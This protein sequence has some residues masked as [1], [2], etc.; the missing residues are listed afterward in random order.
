MSSSDGVGSGVG[1]GNCISMPA[2][3]G[4]LCGRGDI[5]IESLVG[6]GDEDGGGGVDRTS[7]ISFSAHLRSISVVLNLPLPTPL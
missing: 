1:D 6:P 2:P 7:M 3:Y 5:S 4:G